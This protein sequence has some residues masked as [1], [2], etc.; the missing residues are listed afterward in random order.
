MDLGSYDVVEIIVLRIRHLVYENDQ[1]VSYDEFL[2]Y[3]NRVLDLFLIVIC[4]Y[5]YY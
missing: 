4:P 5:D 1:E 3:Y 2:R